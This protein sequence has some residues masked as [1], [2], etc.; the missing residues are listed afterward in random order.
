MS[1]S[2]ILSSVRRR[3]IFFSFVSLVSFI[4]FPFSFCCCFVFPSLS[5]V[6]FFHLP[7]CFLILK[8]QTIFKIKEKGQVDFSTTQDDTRQ[9]LHACRLIRQPKRKKKSERHSSPS[10]ISHRKGSRLHSEEYEQH[11]SSQPIVPI[12][13]NSKW[14][15]FVCVF[16]GKCFSLPAV[17][18]V[19]SQ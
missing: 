16:L 12:T 6:S 11:G 13:I 5:F 1:S 8:F 9:R 2:S 10:I 4:L 7:F 14:G 19:I 15:T 17:F 3:Y 18:I